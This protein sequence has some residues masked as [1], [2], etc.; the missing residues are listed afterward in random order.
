MGMQPGDVSK[1]EKAAM[2]EGRSTRVSRSAAKTFKKVVRAKERAVLKER[3]RKEID[4]A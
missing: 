4:E 1:Q 3:A 2:L